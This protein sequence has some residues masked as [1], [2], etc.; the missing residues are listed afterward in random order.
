MQQKCVYRLYLLS[1]SM[2]GCDP[3]CLVVLL[4][5]D[6]LGVHTEALTA[7]VQVVLADDTV[8]VLAHTALVCT[9]PKLLGMRVP[10]VRV[11]HGC[12]L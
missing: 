5:T 4:E 12:S 1:G 2:F 9:F 11:T 8:A 6:V 7:D 3:N 10:D